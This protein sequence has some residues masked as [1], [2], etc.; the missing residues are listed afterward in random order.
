[1]RASEEVKVGVY[2]KERAMKPRSEKK[3]T[4]KTLKNICPN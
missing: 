4:L 1:M 3:N 2:E